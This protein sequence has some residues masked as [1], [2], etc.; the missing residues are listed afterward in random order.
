MSKG[1]KRQ[2]VTK[3]ALA[4]ITSQQLATVQAIPTEAP[5]P[6]AEPAGEEHPRGRPRKTVK[7]MTFNCRLPAD[8]VAAIDADCKDLISRNAW[9]ALAVGAKLKGS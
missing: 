6:R 9:I 1:F 3:E 2:I 4:D 5:P 7:M 8:V